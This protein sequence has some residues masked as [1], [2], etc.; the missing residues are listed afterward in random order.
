MTT[1]ELEAYDA[2]MASRDMWRDQA[3]D[4]QHELDVA[5]NWVNHHKAHV[6]DLIAENARLR[7]A[8]EKIEGRF[9][10]GEDTLAL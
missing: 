5:D 6:N 8:L 3:C 4:L 9:I 7:D 1:E 10:D 2:M